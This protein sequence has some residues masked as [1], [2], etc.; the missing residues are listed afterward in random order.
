MSETSEHIDASLIGLF[1]KVGYTLLVVV[2]SPFILLSGAI[3]GLVYGVC[4]FGAEAAW[5]IRF[6]W[7]PSCGDER[8]GT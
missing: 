1:G 7:N 4:V 8:P 3:A 5:R 2:I 6:A